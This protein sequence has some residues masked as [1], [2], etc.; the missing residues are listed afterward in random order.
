[1]IEMRAHRYY[2]LDGLKADEARSEPSLVRI[3]ETDSE[4]DKEQVEAHYEVAALEVDWSVVESRD[5]R[6]RWTEVLCMADPS[7]DYILDGHFCRL[8]TSL[9]SMEYD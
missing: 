8:R 7:Q 2:V 1:M 5:F 3:V 6:G 4:I 9:H